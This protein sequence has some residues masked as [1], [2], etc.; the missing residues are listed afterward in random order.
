MKRKKR[1]KYKN[2]KIITSE[3]VFDSQLEYDYYVYLKMRERIG[4]ISNI[5]RQVV[6]ELIPRQTESVIY[7][8]KRGI[9]KTKEVFKEHPVRYKADFVYTENGIEIIAD[10]KGFKTKDYIIKRK[11]MRYQGHPITE[12]HRKS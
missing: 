4:E 9:Q 11:L 10:T 3:G 12:V 8:T 5:R 1:S 6:F 7:T 2:T